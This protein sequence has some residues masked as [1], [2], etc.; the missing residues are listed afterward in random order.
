MNSDAESPSVTAV[1]ATQ[2]EQF[3]AE[4][5][6]RKHDMEG[7]T[8]CDQQVL[9]E[10]LEEAP[11]HLLAYARLEAAWSFADRLSALRP[12]GKAN[13]DTPS[14]K[15]ALHSRV[16]AALIVLGTAGALVANIPPSRPKE[17]AFATPVGGQQTLALDDGSRVELNTDTALRTVIDATRRTV[18]LDKGEAY[19]QIKHDANRPFI[20]FAN[21]RRITD[22][23]TKFVVRS[24]SS[25]LKVALLEGR[26]E[27]DSADDDKQ[28]A[29]I[30]TA[31]DEALATGNTISVTRK[32]IRTVA[33]QLGWQHGVIVFDHTTLAKAAAEF[34]RYNTKKLVV[35]GERVSSITIDGTFP[36]DSVDA[37]VQAAREAFNLR[38]REAGDEVVLSH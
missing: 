35:V 27:V 28:P 15:W 2:I 6:A 10:W 8:S 16:A 7:W 36:K 18:W 33:D 3:A 14:A 34:N 31:G 20:I 23:G 21:G 24:D 38:A 30:L 12:Q 29:T 19:F 4:W 1:T 22:L 26:V 11:A 5:L 9:D 37:F 17:S 25:S 13:P 32:S